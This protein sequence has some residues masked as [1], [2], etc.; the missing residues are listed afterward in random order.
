MKLSEIKIL[1]T[2]DEETYKMLQA[3]QS[4]YGDP[5][6]NIFSRRTGNRSHIIR[7][8]I[9]EKYKSIKGKQNGSKKQRD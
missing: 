5:E 6:E 7:Q 2:M 1:I 4:K 8:L 9:I 3:L